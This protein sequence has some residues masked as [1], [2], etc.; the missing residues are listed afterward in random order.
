MCGSL[1]IIAK[2]FFGRGDTLF[3]ASEKYTRWVDFEYQ[4]L[5][6]NTVQMQQNIFNKTVQLITS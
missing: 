3:L 1:W 5:V 2:S 6:S 4:N